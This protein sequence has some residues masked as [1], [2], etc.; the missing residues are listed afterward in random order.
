[1]LFLLAEKLE[2]IGNTVPSA[3]DLSPGK[4]FFVGDEKQ[5]IYLF[6]GADVSVFRK[7]KEELKTTDLSLK[8]N[9][10]SAPELIGAFN[11][12]FGGSV[13]DPEGSSP[14]SCAPSVFASSETLPLFEA[15]YTPLEAGNSASMTQDSGKLSLCILDKK[16][17]KDQNNENDDPLSADEN[18]TR[19]V[20]E[21]IRKLIDEKKYQGN[22]IAVLFRTRS[23][24]FLFEKHLRLLDIPYTSE[25]INDL[26]YAGPVNDILSV[27]RL[28]A[29]P[30]DSA[31]YAEMLRSPFAGLSLPGTAV[32]L[33]IFCNGNPEPFNDIPLEYL[34]EAD[35]KQYLCGRK[36]YQKIREKTGSESIS[37]LISELWYDEGYRYETQWNSQGRVY[38]ELYD[39]LFHLAVNADNEN[40]GLASFTDSMCSFRDSGGR[41]SETEIPLER[42]GA[43]HLMT[44]HKSKGLEFPVVFLCGCGK[45]SQ[46][47]RI[48]TVFYSNDA[49]LVLSP[50]VPYA[51]RNIS[52]K[53][54]NFFFLCSIDEN[55]PK[56]TAELRRLL[57]VGM[58]RA[59]KELYITGS[60]NL[61]A[62]EEPEDFSIA[63]KTHI[64]EK[65]ADNENLIPGDTILDNDT[66]FGL[67][68][69]SFAHH[70]PPEGLKDGFNFFSLEEIP[71]YS[72]D[73]IKK[74]ESKTPGLSNDHRGL[75]EYIRITEPFYQNT[76]VITTPIIKDN[77]ITP[78]SL[79]N[80]EDEKETLNGKGFAVSDEY[81]GEKADD[82]FEKVDSIL[83]RYSKNSDESTEKFNS[84]SFGTIAHICVEARLKKEEPL[85]PANI[86]GFLA[87]SEM[88]TLI[89]AG[90]EIAHRFVCSPLGIIAGNSRL[91]ESEFPF[92]SIQKN[93]EGKEIFINGTI[94]LFFEE[95]NCFHIVDFKT[96]SREMPGEHVSQMACYFHAVSSLF[97]AKKDCRVWLYYLRTGH[98]VELTESARKFNFK[99]KL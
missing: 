44:I 76:K 96:D 38:S 77:H 98:A 28:A 8:V 13:F 43:V 91:R 34:D 35:K 73:Y 16:N 71:A 86:A 70:I 33:S 63:L 94:D 74:Q 36:V 31:A 66:F 26:F 92:R 45:K 64:E 81:S 41:L 84:G 65:C 24:Q 67:L 3:E 25:D 51:C 40:K 49:G 22:D 90:K 87:P 4:L 11:A 78:V 32:C 6:R 60:V 88:D 21:K 97:T 79:R 80:T 55:R 10:R 62:T 39:Y 82:V 56:R 29:H 46:A 52:G 50:P 9:Y 54:N 18:E 27:L 1:M 83:L 93:K 59:E 68:L 7:L 30:L 47:D 61:K 20:A 57:Y 23:S 48:D 12:I 89:E 19:F 15:S 14:L 17:R 75:K 99:E 42:P 37:S 69:P 95:N 53:R 2:K 85:V 5:S 58:T 72:E